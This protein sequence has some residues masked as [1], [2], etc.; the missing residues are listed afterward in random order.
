MNQL[1]PPAQQTAIYMMSMRRTQTAVA[2]CG[3]Q[4]SSV[5]NP[6]L[7]FEGFGICNLNDRAWDPLYIMEKG[8]RDDIR[9]TIHLRQYCLENCLNRDCIFVD[10]VLDLIRG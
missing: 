2:S 9:L 4:A 3:R 7:R 5:A 8:K 1:V 6:H 10:A